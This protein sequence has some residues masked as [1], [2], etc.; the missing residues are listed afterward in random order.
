MASV[1]LLVTFPARRSKWERL[2]GLEVAG[3]PSAHLRV[4]RPGSQVHLPYG[5]RKCGAP[6]ASSTPAPVKT[7]RGPV[8][9]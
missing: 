3:M 1:A 2:V 6:A 4:E 5:D 7:G 8:D 9:S